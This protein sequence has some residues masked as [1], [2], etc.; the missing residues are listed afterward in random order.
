MTNKSTC[1]L[2]NLTELQ[3]LSGASTA[4]DYSGHLRFIKAHHRWL[5][6]KHLQPLEKLDPIPSDKERQSWNNNGEP[7]LD[8]FI[9]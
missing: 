2:L 6:S 1:E 8:D 3:N 4:P 7:Q 5:K 9:N